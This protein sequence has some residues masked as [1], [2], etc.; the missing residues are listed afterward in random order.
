[1]RRGKK[2]TIEV[3][4]EAYQLLVD[5]ERLGIYGRTVEEVA[6]RFVDRALIQI[7]ETTNE[8]VR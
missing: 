7:H 2:I 8:R 1:M 6:L 3:S 4:L 5:L